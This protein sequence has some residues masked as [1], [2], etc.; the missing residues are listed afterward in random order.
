MSV[1]TSNRFDHS[2]GEKR[3]AGSTSKGKPN[4]PSSLIIRDKGN[5]N[6]GSSVVLRRHRYL[7]IDDLHCCTGETVAGNDDDSRRR[8][9]ASAVAILERYI[10]QV[11]SRIV[12]EVG[13]C[14]RTELVCSK[15][16]VSVSE[17]HLSIERVA[18]DS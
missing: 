5:D 13:N 14:E 10:Q 1:E 15:C 7:L 6:D 18:I 11:G 2:I 16:E 4:S 12:V 8:L 3:R 9:L 17:E